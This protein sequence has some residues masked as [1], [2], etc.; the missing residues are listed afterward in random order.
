MKFDLGAHYRAHCTT[1]A[2]S[3]MHKSKRKCFFEQILEPKY[4]FNLYVKQIPLDSL[5]KKRKTST[6]AQRLHTFN[7]KVP[8]PYQKNSHRQ[9]WPATTA[10][11]FPRKTF[12]WIQM[13]AQTHPEAGKKKCLGF[14]TL[15]FFCRPHWN[16]STEFLKMSI[17]IQNTLFFNASCFFIKN[18]TLKKHAIQKKWSCDT[19]N[20]CVLQEWIAS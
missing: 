10:L 3:C 14:L 9:L 4:F 15:R 7:V 2:P 17:R 19:C 16:E 18:S 8:Y 12:T 5:L 1:C 13:N 6:L 11:S 20:A